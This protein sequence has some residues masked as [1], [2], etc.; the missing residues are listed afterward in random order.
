MRDDGKCCGPK[1]STI[2]V[3]SQELA[4][5]REAVTQLLAQQVNDG[6]N[7]EAMQTIQVLNSLLF[8]D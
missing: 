1:Q 6:R 8:V 5:L 7:D 3:N 4:T 2:Y